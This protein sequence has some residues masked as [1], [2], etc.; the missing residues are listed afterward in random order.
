M[1]L[2]LQAAFVVA[3]L[4][5]A[6]SGAVPAGAAMLAVFITG[7]LLSAPQ[8][9][10]FANV[11]G[12]LSTANAQASDQVGE[13]QEAVLVRNAKGFN[14]GSTLFG[15]MSRLKSEPAESVFYNWWERDPARISFYANTSYSDTAT[16]I[17]FDDGT[18]NPATTGAVWQLLGANGILLN[19]ATGERI[20]VNADP[21][22]DAV[23]VTRHVQG[24]AAATITTGDLFTYVTLAKDEGADPVRAIYNEPTSYVNYCQTFNETTSLTN[25]FKAGILRTDIEGPLRERRAQAL[26]RIANKIEFAYFLGNA[27]AATGANGKIYYTGGI[28]NAIDQAGLTATN[29]LNGHGD[30]GVTLGAF[31]DWMQ[32]FMQVG[33][34][35][36]L[37]FCGPKAYAA[38]SNFANTATGGFRIMNNETIF[39]MNITNIVTPFGE[40]ALAMH[41]LFKQSVAQQGSIF[42]VDLQLIV[43]KVLE[44]LFL[45]TNI[46][47]PGQDS[48]KEQFR[49]KLGIKQKFP[50]AFGYA[51]NLKLITAS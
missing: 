46:Q 28:K 39:G 23:S 36:K 3:M 35:V 2:K 20:R 30:D 43:Q 21:T 49:A 16:T 31:K 50:E 27:E 11:A 29:G 15:L 22:S 12:F 51:Y 19:E 8:G 42:T 4:L 18:G 24:T 1:K 37:A 17:V 38:L 48:Y 34:D 26:E 41:P 10:T 14:T 5:A 9:A 32:S 7:A 45:E 6:I 33:S 47:T 13:W 40:L 25:A 44:P